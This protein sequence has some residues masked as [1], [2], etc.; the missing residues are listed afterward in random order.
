MQGVYN[1]TRSSESTEKLFIHVYT[2]TLSVTFED[3]V[4]C[5]HG[6]AYAFFFEARRVISVSDRSLSPGLDR[7]WEGLKG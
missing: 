7:G 1:T 5:T 3:P 4:G 6:V 2:R